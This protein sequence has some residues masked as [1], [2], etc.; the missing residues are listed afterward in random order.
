MYG[1]GF[2]EFCSGVYRWWIVTTENWQVFPVCV[3]AVKN[4]F[5]K[6]PD[7]TSIAKNLPTANWPQRWRHIGTDYNILKKSYEGY[8]FVQAG[9]MGYKL[10]H[11]VT[12][13]RGDDSPTVV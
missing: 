11:D 10:L 3:N 4:D 1:E 5:F 7:L 6:T 13:D 2:R 8:V 12:H 9:S